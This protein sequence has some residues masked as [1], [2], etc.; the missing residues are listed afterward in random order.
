MQATD[1]ARRVCEL[2]MD[3]LGNHAVLRE[4]RVE[5]AL[6]DARLTQIFEG[7]NQI[8]RLSAIEDE[9]ERLLAVIAAA[10]R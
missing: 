7:T 2:A 9:Q 5:K 8:N 4:E 1:A 10:R 6:R 3:L